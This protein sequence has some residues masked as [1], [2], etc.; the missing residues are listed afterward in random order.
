[1]SRMALKP[2][3]ADIIDQYKSIKDDEK[4]IKSKVSELNTAIKEEMLK[5]NLTS[6]DGNGE[7]CVTLSSSTK[8][9]LDEDRAIEILKESLT[10]TQIKQVIKKKEYIDDDALEKLVYNGKFDMSKLESCRIISA[11]T[12]TLRLSKK[13]G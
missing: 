9:T 11:P 12:Y 6:M 3:F 10:P 5:N 7:Y 4:A 8:E 1:M 2:N 13:K